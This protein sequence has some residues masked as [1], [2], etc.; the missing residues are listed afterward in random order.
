VIWIWWETLVSSKTWTFTILYRWFAWTI[1]SLSSVISI[2]EHFYDALVL[3]WVYYGYMDE[4]DYAKAAEKD[5]IFQWMITDLATRNT[6]TL[7][8]S[9]LRIGE[10]HQF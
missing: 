5:R 8:N 6:N 7:P 9:D 4:K 2:P 1:T 3:R 10:K